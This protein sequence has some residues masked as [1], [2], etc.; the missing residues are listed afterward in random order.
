SFIRRLAIANHLRPSY[1]R[2]YLNDP[3]GEIGSIQVWRLAAVTG[4]TEEE[5]IRV[6]PGLEPVAPRR[7]S[8]PRPQ[9]PQLDPH[10][11]I[12]RAAERD[13]EVKRLSRQ[14]GLRRPTI[15]KALTGQVNTTRFRHRQ[16]HRSP[17]LD[18]VA[19]YLD[20]LIA[21]NPDA[22]IWSIWK[23]LGQERQTTVCYGTVR[24]YVNR[25]RAHP[26]DTR[27]VK[28]LVSRADLFARIR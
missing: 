6:M 2:T 12:R 24:N 18:A 17:I 15:I 26:A 5:L 11:A 22:T 21:D 8:P 20:R 10:I 9:T 19:D 16:P 27:S 13:E 23:K 28:Y 4:R 14:F 7:P 1:L 25:V 3:P